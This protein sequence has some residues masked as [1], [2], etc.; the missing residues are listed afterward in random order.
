MK[1]LF[2]QFAPFVVI[3]VILVIVFFGIMLLAYLFLI[4]LVLG[5]ILYVIRLIRDQF[6]PSP[7]QKPERKSAGRIIDS[8]EWKKL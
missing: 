2:K 8:D 6:F 3:G 7:K 4:G 1:Q 5:S